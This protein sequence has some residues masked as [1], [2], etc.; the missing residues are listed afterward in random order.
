MI[1]LLALVFLAFIPNV[2]ASPVTVSISPTSQAVPQ[3]T[4]AAYTVSL[5]GALAT[6]YSLSLSGLYGAS[7]S[8]GSNPISTPPGGGTG[9]GSTTLSISTSNA[10]GLYCPGTYSFTVAARNSTDGTVPPPGSQP[11]G[12]P[13]PDTGSA[14]ATITVI[15]VGPPLSVTVTTDK[16]AYRIGDKVTIVLSASRPAEGRLTISPPSGTPS[17]FDY[18]LIYGSYSITRTLTANSIGHWTVTF[19]ADDF[20]SGISSAQ[21]A[22]D[23]TP[24]TYD[25]SISLNGVP[26]QY[27][28]QIQV[29]G[30]PQGTIGGAEIKK[31]TF[32]IDT[33]HKISVDPNVAGD[34]G[35][36]YYCAQN[37][38]SVSSSG[39]TTFSYQTQYQFTVD[40]D[41][42]GVAQVTGGGWFPAG[43][44]VQTSQAPQTVTGGAGTQ[45]VLKGWE[46]D[47]VLQSGNPAT[48]TLDKAR[49]A[50]AKYATQYQLVVDS[51]FGSPKGSGYYDAGSTAEFSVTS[52]VG[53]LVQQVFVKWEGDFTGTSPQ[54]SIT[55]DAPKI[56]HA[57][58]TTSYTQLY[59]AVSGYRSGDNRWRV[60]LLAKTT[61]G[62]ARHEANATR[63]RRVRNK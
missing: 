38:F 46:V 44:S 1:F 6:A 63:T 59:I 24:D 10:P 58:W 60:P 14:S 26:P 41:P 31:L 30:Q 61:D 5:S 18:Q 19:Q 34:T 27:S 28:A 16:P 20:C 21:A 55:M 7:A 42:N 52:P 9:A 23:T 8:F 29:D 43:T 11:P 36:R 50:V 3:G 56:V 37:T 12:Y 33:T 45:Y 53:F 35:V 51:P 57:T 39:S 17:T 32:K 49:K 2:H 40:T 13:N 47:G 48:L 62:S 15:Q 54:G 25:V 4:S 22:F